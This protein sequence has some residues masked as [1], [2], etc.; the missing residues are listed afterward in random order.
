MTD[1]EKNRVPEEQQIHDL[2]FGVRRS[3]RY[4]HRRRMYFDRVNKLSSIITAL[5]GSAVIITMLAQCANIAPIIFAALAA[6]FSL[7]DLVLGTAQHARLH[8]DLARRFITLEKAVIAENNMTSERLAELTAARLDI[9]AE[10]PPP[11]IV[12]DTICHNELIRAMGFDET[13]QVKIKWYQRLFANV[14]DLCEQNLRPG[15]TC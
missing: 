11:L 1:N 13:C 15:Q 9:E 7:V 3:I 5:S 6:V 8:N 10:E 12:L 14:I 2:L 4:H